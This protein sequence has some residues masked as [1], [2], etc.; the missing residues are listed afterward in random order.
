MG[1]I[2]GLEGVYKIFVDSA[3]KHLLEGLVGGVV[4]FEQCGG[5]S[6]GL[7]F[8]VNDSSSGAGSDDCGG[9]M[10]D[11]RDKSGGVEGVVDIWGDR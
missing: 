5:V 1:Y 4:L 9:A 10:I 2:I 11:Q 6:E 3:E 7:A 8:V